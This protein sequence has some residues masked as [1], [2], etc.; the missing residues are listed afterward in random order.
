M[1]DRMGSQPGQENPFHRHP[2][3]DEVL[4]FVS[5]SGECVVGEAVYPVK[6]DDL[7]LAPKDAPH[8]VRNA[9]SENLDCILAQSRLPAITYRHGVVRFA[10]R[11][12]MIQ[13]LHL[14]TAADWMT[15]GDR[16]WNQPR[17]RSRSLPVVWSHRMTRT[18]APQEL[19]EMLESVTVFDVRRKADH[20]ADPATE[21]P[22]T[23]R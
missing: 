15:R 7:V 22:P 18:I 13:R 4:H 1:A 6:P 8:A 3:S 2:L 12:P 19:K 16:G 17:D 14:E 23:K 5:G 20:D 11:Q 9:G 10:G 21:S